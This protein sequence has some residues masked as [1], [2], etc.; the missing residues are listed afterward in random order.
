MADMFDLF[1]S[2]SK[3]CDMI[4]ETAELVAERFRPLEKEASP[5]AAGCTIILTSALAAVP[6]ET[7][8]QVDDLPAFLRRIAELAE[9]PKSPAHRLALLRIIGLVVN[10]WITSSADVGQV[11]QISQTLLSSITA[12]PS[13]D[14]AIE[15]LRVVFWVAKAL[16][17][18]AE[19]L[20]MEITL[21]LVSL[22]ALPD[23]GVPASRGFAVLLGE[24]EFL[25][26]ANHAVVR[27]LYKQRTFA[28]CVPRIVEGFKAADSGIASPSSPPPPPPQSPL[29]SR[30]MQARNRTSS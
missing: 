7:P 6:R 2:H 26:R 1:V 30:A 17:L 23:L 10:K 24:D 3:A 29:K 28:Q 19:K 13:N 16:L 22:L 11:K 14:K 20:G 27:L 21:S 5:E 12:S 8:L 25:N 9:T 18:R 4:A 15:N